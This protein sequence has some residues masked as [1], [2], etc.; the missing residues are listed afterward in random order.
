VFLVRSLYL[1][2]ISFLLVIVGGCFIEA[3]TKHTKLSNDVANLEFV[4][5]TCLLFFVLAILVKREHVSSL[6]YSIYSSC[7]DVSVYMILLF[8]YTLE[9]RDTKTKTITRNRHIF[10]VL[11]V[12]DIITLLINDLTHF[13]FSMKDIYVDGKFFGWVPVYHPQYIVHLILCYGLGVIIVFRFIKDAKAAPKFYKAKYLIVLAIFILILLIN[14]GVKVLFKDNHLDFSLIAYGIFMIVGF[15]FTSYLLPRGLK[16]NMLSVASDNISD[17]VICFDYS[18][19]CIYENKLARKLNVEGA[20]NAE[21]LEPYF[22]SKELYIVR[23]EKIV[24]DGKERLF[25]V[26]FRCIKDKTGK[27]SGYYVKLDDLTNE[28]EAIEREQY[29][30]THDELTGLYNR[31]FF[32]AEMERILKETPDVPRYLVATDIMNFKLVNDL[33]GTKFGDNILK[34]QAEMISKAK[35]RDCIIGRVSGDKF[36]MMIP[37]SFFNPEL[38]VKN[39]KKITEFDNKINFRMNMKLGLYEIANPYENVHT[40]WDKANLAIQNNQDKNQILCVYDTS[41]MNKIMHENTIISEFK[42]AIEQDLL[43]MFIQPQIEAKTGKCIGGEALCRW[44]DKNGY[45][46]PSE[47]IPI[48]EKAGFIYNL[49]YYIW[50]KAVQKLKDWKDKKIDYHISVNISVKDFY[51]ADIYSIFVQLV[52]KYGVSPEKLHLEI[53]ESVIIG[54]NSFHRGILKKLQDYGFSIEMDDFGSG[55]SSLNALKEM[56]MDVLKIDMEFLHATGNEERGRVV[57]SAIVRMAKDLGMK[58]ISEGVENEGQ[59]KFL[60]SIDVD[61]LQG[62]LFSKPVTVEEFEHKYVE[63][64]A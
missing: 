43:C 25:D 15:A 42:Y 49:D 59:A 16:R 51:Y 52:E 53:T 41:L 8:L 5:F 2:I 32:F 62:Y 55:F 12:M 23:Q 26:E 20:D 57:V 47:F 60:K 1:I 64:E 44:Y 18:G 54:D 36:G 40:M 3:V 19:K 31:K 56:K 61:I 63:A 21:W 45:R 48:L 6:F 27:T 28:Q 46:Q 30:S 33:F 10:E 24:L 4:C 17:A 38:A 34:F 37:K 22:E 14:A 58:V 9:H 11:A 39:T 29:R 50:E 13:Y 35:F 7:L